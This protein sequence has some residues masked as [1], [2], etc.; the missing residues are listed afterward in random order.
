MGGKVKESLATVGFTEGGGSTQG[1]ARVYERRT[2]VLALG[3]V[4]LLGMEVKNSL[5]PV[6]SK[7]EVS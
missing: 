6:A 7:R 4:G 2:L 5:A 1:P 3:F